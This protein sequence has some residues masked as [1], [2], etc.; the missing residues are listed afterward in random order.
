MYY[1]NVVCIYCVFLYICVHVLQVSE[2]DQTF[3]LLLICFAVMTTYVKIF[4]TTYVKT[5]G[6]CPD[7]FAQKLK[8]QIDSDKI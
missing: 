1:M 8:N 7:M 2:V 6:T 3:S 5:F 4:G